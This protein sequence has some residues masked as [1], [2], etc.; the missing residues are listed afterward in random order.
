M[1]NSSFT[2]DHEEKARRLEDI[3]AELASWR[4]DPSQSIPFAASKIKAAVKQ[5]TE[6]V[7]TSSLYHLHRSDIGRRIL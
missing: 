7:S 5:F 6:L 2:D 3:F 4:K 1:D